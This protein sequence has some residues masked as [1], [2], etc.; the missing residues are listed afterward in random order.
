[1]KKKALRLLLRK[2]QK[3]HSSINL[4]EKKRFIISRWYQLHTVIINVYYSI[5]VTLDNVISSNI[6]IA[7][8]PAVPSTLS[9]HN[10]FG[11]KLICILKY[12]TRY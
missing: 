7:N 9:R 6:S 12:P 8:Q 2:L 4:T 10:Q 11:R 1:M 5:R 3:I